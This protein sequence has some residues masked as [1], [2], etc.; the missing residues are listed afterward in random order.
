MLF[1]F[2]D[3]F[4]EK[5]GIA[6]ICYIQGQIWVQVSHLFFL[7]TS[8]L[9]N[10]PILTLSLPII[11]HLVF[12]LSRFVT[13]NICYHLCL[14]SNGVVWVEQ[15]K[16]VKYFEGSVDTG[17][18]ALEPGYLGSHSGFA[19]CLPCELGQTVLCSFSLPSKQVI[20]PP[21]SED[22]YQD[23]RRWCPSSIQHSC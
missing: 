18:P 19:I 4:H 23:Y 9:L 13:N 15:Y 16:N 8:S 5:H 21:A 14:I 3:I 22:Y 10:K 6:K 2:C 7:K 1:C 11:I 20:I 17:K 12:I